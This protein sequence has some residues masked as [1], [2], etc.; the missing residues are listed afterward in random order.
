MSLRPIAINVDE[1]QWMEEAKLVAVAT[2]RSHAPVEDDLKDLVDNPRWGTNGVILLTDKALPHAESIPRL[3]VVRVDEIMRDCPSDATLELVERVGSQDPLRIAVVGAHGRAGSSVFTA[4]LAAAIESILEEDVLVVDRDPHSQGL[5]TVLGVEN[6]PSWV[7][8]DPNAETSEER[9]LQNCAVL[10]NVNVLSR[11][12]RARLY[13]PWDPNDE[14]SVAGLSRVLPRT[15]L[16]V[17]C[18]RTLPHGEEWEQ[19][20]EDC[21]P[22]VVVVVSAQNVSGIV[23]AKD[24]LD[25]CADQGVFPGLSVMRKLRDGGCSY[26]MMLALLGRE[27]DASWTHDPNL[28]YDL[29]RGAL[30]VTSSPL[31]KAARKI[32]VE[33]IACRMDGAA[34][35]GDAAQLG[36]T[37]QLSVQVRR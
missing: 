4:G 13:G 8:T 1:P 2:G 17:D 15:H 3:A 31:A 22:D 32:A 37:A 9:L 36:G 16:V 35:L 19:Q 10:G 18:G 6:Q 27:P 29:D 26:G 7:S 25:L 12:A 11:T 14:L 23:A 24:V 33:I 20:W 5:A 34:Q 28:V 30:N 21:A